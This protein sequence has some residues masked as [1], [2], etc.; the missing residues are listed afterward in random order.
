[1]GWFQRVNDSTPSGTGNW[2]SAICKSLWDLWMLWQ[3]EMQAC[4][5]KIKTSFCIRDS[6]FSF[7]SR[8][9]V[10]CTNRAGIFVSPLALT[11]ALLLSARH[12]L[13]APLITTVYPKIMK[14]LI[15]CTEIHLMKC[16][17][18]ESLLRIEL[19]V[20]RYFRQR[21]YWKNDE[22]EFVNSPYQGS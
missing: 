21:S 18:N 9:F 2:D 1:M 13:S 19:S 14:T 22:V 10:T 3:S 15:K 16:H 5:R 12:Y 17:I 11:T 4:S 20:T 6:H 8:N 7:H